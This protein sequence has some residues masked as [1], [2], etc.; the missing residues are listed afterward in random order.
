MKQTLVEIHN[1]HLN[2]AR[3]LDQLKTDIEK[4]Q[5]ST[6]PDF[7][8]LYDIMNYLT[9]YPDVSHHPIEEIIFARLKRKAPESI[10]LINQLNSEHKELAKLGHIL[11]EEL[12]KVTSGAIVSK[13]NIL[14]AA[15][16][17][18][19]LLSN[20]MNVE[21]SQ[22]FPIIENMLTH[23]DWLLLDVQI[24]A[25]TDTLFGDAIQE[26][27]SDLYKRITLSKDEAA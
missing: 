5:Q 27:F 22:I 3:L 12:Q 15:K 19:E 2:Y 20:H 6:N 8:R 18:C 24:S 9:N 1:D 17:Y 10:G 14:N 4:L 13:D 16:D 21:E 23:E 11:K 7:I 26:Q 25:L